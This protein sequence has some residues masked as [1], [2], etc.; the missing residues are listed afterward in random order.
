[1][2]T[3]S[4]SSTRP[5]VLL[6]ITRLG[7]GGAERVAFSL[8]ETLRDRVDFGVF[9]AYASVEDDVGAAMRAQL[10]TLGVPWFPGTTLDVKRG[11]L[12]IAGWR[13][14][15]AVKQFRPDCVHYHAEISEACG[16]VMRNWAPGRR[17]V[18][19]LRTVHNSIFWRFW[20]RIG[21]WVDREIADAAIV[22]VSRAARDEFL[23]YRADSGAPATQPAIIYNGVDLPAQEPRAF[24]AD[25]RQPRLLFAGRFELQKGPDLLADA[26]AG[27]RLSDGMTPTLVMFGHGAL[28]P[29][30]RALAGQPPRGWHVELRPPTPSLVQEMDGFDLAVI[31]SRFEGLP[32]LSVEATLRGLPVIAADAP[33]LRETLPVAHPWKFPVEDAPALAQRL[34]EVL[35][36]PSSWASTVRAAQD[37]AQAHFSPGAMASAYLPLYLSCRARAQRVQTVRP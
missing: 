6:A 8:I 21:R 35:A 7:L 16:A 31:P 27:V 37:F 32:L 19:A 4:P 22:C 17:R 11:G 29:R 23:R 33:G 13:L 15:Q 24:P 9:T 18:P 36:A 2:T 5:R 3:E 30:L 10:A 1:M 25:R 34:T 26:L 14:A 28:E 12:L 20:P